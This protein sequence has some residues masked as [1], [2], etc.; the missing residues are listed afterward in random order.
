MVL[1]RDPRRPQLERVDGHLIF[2]GA[3]GWPRYFYWQRFSNVPGDG[4][5]AILVNETDIHIS[6]VHRFEPAVKAGSSP[7]DSLRH[8]DRYVLV[9]TIKL[10]QLPFLETQAMS[11]G[12]SPIF[13]D[14][15]R[16]FAEAHGSDSQ[17][18]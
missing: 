4:R 7:D 15:S 2:V 5:R 13:D 8:S 18:R 12:H 3:Q 6:D 1:D 16:D 10:N 14:Q 9:A 17:S 11:V